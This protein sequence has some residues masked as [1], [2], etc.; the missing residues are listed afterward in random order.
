MLTYLKSAVF[1][2]A[3]VVSVL[4]YIFRERTVEILFEYFYWV[5]LTWLAVPILSFT[6]LVALGQQR[7]TVIDLES[8]F[9]AKSL[10]RFW[11][12]HFAFTMA[13]FVLAYALTLSLVIMGMI[14][15]N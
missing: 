9:V 15:L 14:S 12:V 2:A 10:L 13:V 5:P 3:L 8:S 7:D 4:M 11:L 1:A 6:W